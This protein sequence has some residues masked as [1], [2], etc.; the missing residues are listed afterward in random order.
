MTSV[1]PDFEHRV[2][3]HS[4]PHTYHPTGHVF[5]VSLPA[6]ISTHRDPEAVEVFRAFVEELCHRQGLTTAI[7]HPNTYAITWTGDEIG[8]TC[9][10]IAPSLVIDPNPDA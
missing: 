6:E 5:G 4:Q 3:D 10:P 7:D 9:W 8:I 2:L 1:L